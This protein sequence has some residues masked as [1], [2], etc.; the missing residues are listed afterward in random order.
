MQD[1][2]N[3]SQSG[4]L[5]VNLGTPEQPT[6]AAVRKYL[7]EFLMDPYVIDLP[8]LMRRI[9]VSLFVLPWRPRTTAAAYT[10]IWT[11]QG[12]PLLI[13]SQALRTKVEHYFPG[14]VR[15]AMRYGK[16]DI[17]SAMT[18]LA[19][20]TQTVLVAPLY[21]HYAQSTILTTLELVRQINRNL[22]LNLHELTPFY[23]APKYINALAESIQPYLDNTDML[24]FSYHGLP[25][26]HIRKSDPT[27]SHCLATPDCCQKQA[28]AQA[29]C[30]RYQVYKTTQLV[31]DTLQLKPDKYRI[32]FQ[33]RLGRNPWLKPYT[34]QM[35][36]QLATS[37]VKRLAVVCP[38]FVVDNLE[39]LEEINIKGRESY[40]NAGGES[41]QVIPCLNCNE[42]WAKD[43]AELC[44]K[45]LS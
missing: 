14:P 21:P 37:G 19:K 33:S 13:N 34:R 44:C 22:H 9:L 43:F 27:G 5:I 36:P 7:N 31:A 29:T 4:L 30:Y 39:T 26:S 16:P 40:L 12:S 24:L 3:P 38:A 28:V 10:R 18:E 25:E 20:I 41:L 17:S 6:T 2:T 1:N 11:D 35:L 15:L 42:Q 8:W 45:A 23:D 32:S